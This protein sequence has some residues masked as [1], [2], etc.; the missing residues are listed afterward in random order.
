MTLL[1]WRPYGDIMR[2]NDG[3]NRM[4]D[5][6]FFKKEIQDMEGISDWT[7][8][9]DIF[10][11]KDNFVFRIE[12]PGMKKEDIE[13]DMKDN[14]LTISGERKENS[15][16][17]KEDFHRMESFY[18]SFNRSFSIPKGTDPKKI[19]A[20]MKDGILELKIGKS[21]EVKSKKIPI[22]IK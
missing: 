17:K 6:E 3:I 2:F 8:S 15:E 22:T 5:N 14:I 10:E 12:V 21:E 7:P 20:V 1:K 13:I 4:F 11:T 16:I 18:G 19:D 9:T